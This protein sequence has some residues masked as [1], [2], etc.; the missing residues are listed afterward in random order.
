MTTNLTISA[1]FTKLNGQPATGLTLS[2]ISLF[3]TSQNKSTGVDTTVWDGTQV[4]TIEINNVGMYTRILTT[5]DLTVNDYFAMAQYTGAT[6][7]DS[8][9]AYGQVSMVEAN[10]MQI[11]SA[12]ATDQINAEV[13]D[14]LNV[15][16]YAEP[17]S[18]PAATASLVAKIGW[19]MSL[20]RNKILQTAAL[21]SLR[22]DGD[23]GNIGTAVVSDDGTT[24]TRNEWS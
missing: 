19:L 20:A 17:G 2:Q 16:T 1:T 3:L 23:S 8:N 12:D 14:A 9:Y 11:E 24:A 22:N 21:Q 10:T 18:V 5:A 15:D 6:V 13:V 4:A 7:L